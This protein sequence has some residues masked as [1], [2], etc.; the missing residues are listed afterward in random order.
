MK[1]RYRDSHMKY[2]NSER[3][4]LIGKILKILVPNS[5]PS[6]RISQETLPAFNNWTLKAVIP[7]NNKLLAALTA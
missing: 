2:P 3:L 7:S 4:L 1:S 5:H 6:K